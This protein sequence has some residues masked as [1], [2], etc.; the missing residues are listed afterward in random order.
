MYQHILNNQSNH[1]LPPRPPRRFPPPLLKPP[2][3]APPRLIPPLFV[4]PRLPPPL[5]LLATTLGPL[6][7]FALSKFGPTPWVLNTRKGFFCLLSF[8]H[9]SLFGP[10]PSLLCPFPPPS[11]PPSDL[12]FLALNLA[13]FGMEA[14][15]D[16]PLRFLC[17]CALNMSLSGFSPT[18]FRNHSASSSSSLSAGESAEALN[19]SGRFALD[20]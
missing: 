5:P 7:G 8:D 20:T 9:P 14:E 16:E 19:P 13:M 12:N 6:L 3:A 2:R 15:E 1:F 10:W 4:P 11:F 18:S 17:C